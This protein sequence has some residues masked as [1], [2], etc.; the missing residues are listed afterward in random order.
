M[1]PHGW[2]DY[3]DAPDDIPSAFT[4]VI[5]PVGSTPRVIGEWNSEAD[6]LAVAQTHYAHAYSHGEVHVVEMEAHYAD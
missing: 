3:G 6:A 5:A 1:P 2:A 4:I